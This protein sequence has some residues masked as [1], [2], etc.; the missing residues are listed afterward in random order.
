MLSMETIS[1]MTVDALS[2]CR[3]PKSVGLECHAC[4]FG[5]Y[6]HESYKTIRLNN[7][8]KGDRRRLATVAGRPQTT[9]T[10]P[11]ISILRCMRP[12]CFLYNGDFFIANLWNADTVKPF[13]M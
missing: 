10:P 7:L 5:F 2:I 9:G 6:A 12:C 8:K 13:L 3:A 11:L 4:R 1:H